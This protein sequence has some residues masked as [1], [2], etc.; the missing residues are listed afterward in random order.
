MLS[1]GT[2]GISAQLLEQLP[3]VEQADAPAPATPTEMASQNQAKANADLSADQT[4]VVELRGD[5]GQRSKRLLE[6][7]LRA[8]DAQ[9]ATRLIVQVD[10]RTGDLDVA[11]EL[12][13]LLSD[14]AVE[15]IVY[16]A[17]D[18]AGP[19][20]VLP[21][22]ASE[23]WV[24]PRA[25]IG[26]IVLETDASDDAV[27]LDSFRESK[28]L[29]STA[30]KPNRERLVQAMFDPTISFEFAGETLSASGRLLALR[31]RQALLTDAAGTSLLAT[32]SASSLE[33]LLVE[34]TGA[35]EPAYLAI[36]W[37]ARR[38][39][40]V[41][42][43]ID[44]GRSESAP[45]AVADAAAP[46]S[47]EGETVAEALPEDGK[48]DVYVV[49]IQGQIADPQ[50]YILRRALKQ[51]IEN[52]VEAVLLEMDTFGGALNTT[53]DMMEALARFE[54]L[55]MTFVNSKAIS[56]GSYISIATKDIYM[57][58]TGTIGSSDVVSGGGQEV[59]PTAK[60]KIYS[61]IDGILRN[62]T[63]EYPFRLRVM[64]A[65]Y[66]A[67]NELTINNEPVVS[68]EGEPLAPPGEL[69]TLTASEAVRTYVPED[70]ERFGYEPRPLLASGI[71]NSVEEVLNARFG[72]GNYRITTFEVTWSEKVAKWL[73]TV[74]PLLFPLGL[75]LL[76]LEA[77]SP[78]FGLL[79]G[80]GILL[81]LTFFGGHLVAGLAG[82]EDVLLFLIGV[83]LILVELFFF[84]GTIVIGLSGATLVLASLIWAMSDN[85]PAEGFDFSAELLLMPTLRLIFGLVFGIVLLALLARF[86]P[87][88]GVWN[89]LILQGTLQPAGHAPVGDLLMEETTSGADASQ[90]D[91]PQIGSTG[92]AI[93]NLYPSGEIEINGRRYQARTSM[94]MIQRGAAVKV[95]R[96]RDFTLVVTQDG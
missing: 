85:W 88:K 46:S 1:L 56:A 40:I 84:P 58:P 75:I 13:Q 4:V 20:A 12:M 57:A 25:V 19:A 11:I 68:V 77:Q 74:A 21:L 44:P 28:I 66:D 36:T 65:M 53:I 34:V 70:V 49:P 38:R 81:L 95:V 50:L 80:L 24:H 59:P 7:A 55:T 87:K 64:R 39:S 14:S 82:Y 91:R 47:A 96:Y 5:I 17:E 51:A 89:R 92:T 42:T 67:S 16:V 69:L 52:D 79:G 76:Y 83:I 8:A 10:S 41:E 54:G 9:G 72:A 27:A 90:S 37:D 78:S 18:A 86:L 60:K 32:G 30:P 29:T 45:P 93:T 61:L 3:S 48:Y 2:V 73:V 15:A 43:Q 62:Y 33:E 23:V 6:Q 71:A 35:A 22:A 31:A 63:D 26:P 94:G